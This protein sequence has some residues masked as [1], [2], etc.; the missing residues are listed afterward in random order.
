MSKLH[1]CL[2]GAMLAS[3]GYQG[4]PEYDEEHPSV[5]PDDLGAL[6]ACGAEDEFAVQRAST[7]LTIQEGAAIF[8]EWMRFLDIRAWHVLGCFDLHRTVDK[9]PRHA[10]NDLW[11]RLKTMP[12]LK[13]L[14]VTYFKFETNAWRVLDRRNEWHWLAEKVDGIVIVTEEKGH[15]DITNNGVTVTRSSLGHP[16]IIVMNGGKGD[17]LALCGVPG[18]LVDD[19]LCNLEHFVWRGMLPS[20]GILVPGR[21]WPWF[22]Y[23]ELIEKRVVAVSWNHQAWV[24]VIRAFYDTSIKMGWV[25]RKK[26]CFL[27][28][29]RNQQASSS[30]KR[31]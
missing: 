23:K 20:T 31:H 10:C 30:T 26:C 9:L 15:D 25:D 12:G 24:A 7:T 18:I 13:T 17:V 22:R 29:H 14:I 2:P 5:C 27:A 6:F 21:D 8:G 4:S 11:N 1:F 19:K 3:P 28:T 16:K